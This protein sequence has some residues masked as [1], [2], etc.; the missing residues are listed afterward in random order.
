MSDP[1]NPLRPLRVLTVDNDRNAADSLATV[2]NHWGHE[3][4]AVYG[5]QEALDA[6]L[7]FRPDVFLLDFGMP[8][9]NGGKVA[10]ELRSRPGERP[11]LVTVTGYSPRWVG[12]LFPSVFDHCLAKP[13]VF[14]E[15]H[16]ILA[17]AR[18]LPDA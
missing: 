3:A 18:K 15:L 1:I 9:M 17:A 12:Q 2:L 5:G 6:A 4:R 11:M 7:A 14:P 13:L 8:A 10:Q 16:A